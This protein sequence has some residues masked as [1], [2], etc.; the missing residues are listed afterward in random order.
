M[1]MIRCFFLILIFFGCNSSGI[2]QSKKKIQTTVNELNCILESVE[3]SD[4]LNDKFEVIKKRLDFLACQMINLRKESIKRSDRW[5]KLDLETR[6]LE[7]QLERIFNIE[8][9]LEIYESCALDALY[10]LDAFERDLFYPSFEKRKNNY[11]L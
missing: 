5:Y 3:S 7:A 6:K 10:R 2:E 8:G 4:D 1:Q 9:C 11:H